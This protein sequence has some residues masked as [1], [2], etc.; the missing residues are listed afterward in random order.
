MPINNYYIVA[1]TK[2]AKVLVQEIRSNL[3]SGDYPDE[4]AK[5]LKVGTAKATETG[6][7]I[8]IVFTAPMSAAFE[9]GSGEHGPDGERYRIEPK[10]VGALAFEW[11][12]TPAGPGEKFIG[13]AGDGRLLFRYVDHPGIEARPYIAPAIDAKRDEMKKILGLPA[14]III[15]DGRPK[16]TVIV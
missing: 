5:G 8:R 7:E 14:K 10:D 11:D 3:R 12:K 6:G 16:K 15:R 13:Q 9:R 1:L 4:I 2:A